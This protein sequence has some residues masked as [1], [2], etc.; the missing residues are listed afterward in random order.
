MRTGGIKRGLL[1]ASIALVVGLAIVPGAI[2]STVTVSGGN[3]IRVAET[4]N[5]T[6][7][8]SVKYDSGT[9]VYT[10]KDAAANLTP[11]GTCAAVDTHTA[12][13]PGAGITRIS[14]DT[15]DRDDTITLDLATIPSTVNEDLDGGGGNDSVLGANS[16]GTLNGGSG[17]DIVAGRGTVDGDAGND[18]VTGSPAP[19]TIRGG[20]G[21]DL[22]DGGGGPDDIAGGGGTDTLTYPASRQTPVN[23]TIGSGNGNDGGVEDQGPGG[24]DTIHGDIETVIGTAAGDFLAGDN[25]AETVLGMG[26]DDLLAGN[27]GNDTLGGFLGNDLML[28][29]TGNDTLRGSFGNDRELGGPGDDRVA[30]GP[31]DDFLKGNQGVDVMKG[32]T[33]NDQVRARDHTRDL[34]ISCGPGPNGLESATR[35]RRLDPPA[36]S[37]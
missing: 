6:N 35:D 37:C 33:G 21:R 34:K 23:V 11:S 22:V 28:G 5:E 14:V 9:D 32:K 15:A 20:T 29:G 10:V 19:D 7:Q 3:T 17:N 2:A 31:D 26:G 25:S 36:K 1:G 13:C 4:G 12:T 30:G 27:G 16:P 18:V 24:R 8:I